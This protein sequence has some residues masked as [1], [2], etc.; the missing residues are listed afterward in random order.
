MMRVVAGGGLLCAVALTVYLRQ[1]VCKDWEE[2]SGTPAL[3]WFIQFWVTLCLFLWCITV[4]GVVGWFVY[5]VYRVLRFI[6]VGGE[7]LS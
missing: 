7:I 1:L 6:L 2:L 5:L 4:T 3:R